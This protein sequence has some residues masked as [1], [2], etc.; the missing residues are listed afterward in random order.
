MASILKIA[1]FIA[2]LIGIASATDGGDVSQYYGASTFQ[3]CRNNGWNF[4]IVRSY[5][6]YGA[7]DANAPATLAQ[8]KAAGI[9]YRDVYHFPCMG[10]VSAAKQVA[11][12][13]ANVRGQFGM[14]W[15]DVETNPSPGCG[16]SS[17]QAANCQFLRELIAAGNSHGIKMGIYSSSYMWS[18]IMGNGYTVGAASGLPIWYAHYDGART[19]SD[20]RPFGG[21]TRPA[22]KQY[23]DHVGMCGINADA[24]WY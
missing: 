20:F 10:K 6:S 8:A 17:S 3:C 11:D 21:W 22:I 1:L 24:N 12:N 23:A 9:P 5:C 4:V 15:F 18:S 16:F 2:A 14:M 7:P 13:F 19:F